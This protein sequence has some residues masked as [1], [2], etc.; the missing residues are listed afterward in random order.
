MYNLFEGFSEGYYIGRYIT[1]LHMIHG[2]K[3]RR[4]PRTKVAGDSIIMEITSTSH[5]NQV[6]DLED[7]AMRANLVL[8]VSASL[9]LALATVSL[10]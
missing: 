4:K 5:L 9:K 7:K 1:T 2:P 10:F 3:Q 6:R 8:C